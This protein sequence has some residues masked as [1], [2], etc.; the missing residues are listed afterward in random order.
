MTV[1]ADMFTGLTS[2]VTDNAE[3]LIPVGVGVMAILLGIRMIPRI[4]HTFF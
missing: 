3:V 4:L 2:A 1:T